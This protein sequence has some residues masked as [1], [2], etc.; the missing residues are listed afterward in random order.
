M[1]KVGSRHR[2]VTRSRPDT[3]RG[4]FVCSDRRRVRS[5]ELVS[6]AGR[7]D[8]N[9]GAAPEHAYNLLL[10]SAGGLKIKGEDNLVTEIA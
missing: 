7:H 9:H 5:G 2:A 3:H 4:V 10:S 8:S 6:E 1:T